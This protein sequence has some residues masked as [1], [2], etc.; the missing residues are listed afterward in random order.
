M[1]QVLMTQHDTMVK[2]NVDT[3]RPIH[4]P[5]FICPKC[6][7]HRTEVVGMSE[8]E[9][10]VIRCNVCGERST[11]TSIAPPT[12][13]DEQV[14]GELVA[15]QT[16]GSALSRLKDPGARMRVLRWACDRFE[17]ADVLAQLQATPTAGRQVAAAPAEAEGDADLTMEGVELFYTT[18][19]IAK[20]EETEAAT[21]GAAPVA[22]VPAAIAAPG[23]AGLDSMVRGFVSDFQ[24]IALEWQ[25]A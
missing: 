15:M 2:Y 25:R 5:P 13:N 10:W 19:E 24:E 12:T 23:D 21:V 16:V 6:G 20:P 1:V 17:V 3:K 8:H 7:S 18:E 22:V 4:T 9:T 11:V 14:D